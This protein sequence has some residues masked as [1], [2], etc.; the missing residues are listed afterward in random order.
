MIN[1]FYLEL[2]TGLFNT[3]ATV[4][5]NPWHHVLPITLNTGSPQG[6]VLSP[7]FMLFTYDCSAKYPGSRIVKF[8]DDTAVVGLISH[9]DKSSYRQEVK[10][11]V[12]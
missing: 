6:C 12:H 5:Q 7:L 4:C 3:P 10:D 2:D 9:N 1:T 8:A 11:L